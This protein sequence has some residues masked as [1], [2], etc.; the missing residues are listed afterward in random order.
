MRD[1]TPPLMATLLVCIID[2]YGYHTLQILYSARIVTCM[3]LRT[4][5]TVFFHSLQMRDD[6]VNA[7]LH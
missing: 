4:Y 1:F 3:A 6:C 7:R 5:Q 2:N